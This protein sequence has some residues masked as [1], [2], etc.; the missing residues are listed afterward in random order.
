MP[1]WR[2]LRQ[3]F[4][5]WRTSQLANGSA[6]IPPGKKICVNLI[7]DKW[8]TYDSLLYFDD[9]TKTDTSCVREFHVRFVSCRPQM[10]PLLD[11]LAELLRN[12]WDHFSPSC[13]DLVISSSLDFVSGLIVEYDHE[14]MPVW[15]LIILCIWYCQASSGFRW[16]NVPPV[17]RGGFEPWRV[18]R[19]LPWYSRFHLIF[20][21]P[22]TF[23]S[24]PTW[25]ITL[26]M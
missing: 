17:I 9:F 20:R 18:S 21:W 26:M 10:H 7:T 2:T 22:H 11:Y 24:F 3:H 4:P 6:Y 19:H 16:T 25:S 5:T 1:A 8:I 15:L 12:S 13:A 14:N 23:R